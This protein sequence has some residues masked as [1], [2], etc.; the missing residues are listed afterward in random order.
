MSKQVCQVVGCVEHATEHAELEVITADNKEIWT[1]VHICTSCDA[2]FRDYFHNEKA[3]TFDGYLVEKVSI[4]HEPPNEEGFAV[5]IGIWWEFAEEVD[6]DEFDYLNVGLF[7][8]EPL[9]IDAAMV[10]VEMD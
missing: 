7:D 4:L 3:I 1:D 2:L 5:C 10:D 8:K 6:F 9:Q